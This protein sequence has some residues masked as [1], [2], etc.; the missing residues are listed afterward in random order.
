[1]PPAVRAEFSRS[2][3]AD[4]V[5]NAGDGPSVYLCGNSLGLLPKRAR[6]IMSEELDVWSRRYATESENVAVQTA[7]DTR[8]ATPQQGRDGPLQPPPQAAMEGYRRYRRARARPGRRSARF[9]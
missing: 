6:T 2:R 8:E 7:A 1:M 5:R 9:R 3:H 4:P